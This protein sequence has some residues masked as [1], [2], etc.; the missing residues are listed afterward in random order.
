MSCRVSCLL[1]AASA[2]GNQL[3]YCLMLIE[4]QLMAMS[5]RPYAP[6]AR[7]TQTLLLVSMLVDMLEPIWITAGGWQYSALCDG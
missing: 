7:P 4:V 3:E 1:I 6:T 2:D 5:N